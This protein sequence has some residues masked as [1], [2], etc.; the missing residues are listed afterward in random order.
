MKRANRKE[1]FQREEGKW[2]RKGDEGKTLTTR[3]KGE[4]NWGAWKKKGFK[5][6]SHSNTTTKRKDEERVE[7]ELGGN[8]KIEKK[9]EQRV[10]GVTRV[11]KGSFLKKIWRRGKGNDG[12]S[13]HGSAKR[14]RAPPVWGGRRREMGERLREDKKRGK[15]AAQQVKNWS[16]VQ[17]DWGADARGD[18]KRTTKKP[19]KVI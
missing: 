5:G 2:E 13:H 4:G 18:E 10:P 17:F 3:R 15:I 8:K 11:R 6:K 9:K 14:G 16:G 1:N 19:A 12:V 7:S